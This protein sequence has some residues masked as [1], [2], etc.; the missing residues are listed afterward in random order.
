[1]SAVNLCV[2]G[3]LIPCETVKGCCI[4]ASENTLRKQ[5]HVHI[6]QQFRL[7]TEGKVSVTG[8]L[9]YGVYALALPQLE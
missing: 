5:L 8:K 4:I 6:I 7:S 3:V 2:R 9:D 1:M